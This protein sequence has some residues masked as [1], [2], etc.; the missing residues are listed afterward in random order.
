MALHLARVDV[1]STGSV[2]YEIRDDDGLLALGDSVEANHGGDAVVTATEL[3]D[4]EYRALEHLRRVD[5]ATYRLA[6]HQI[7]SRTTTW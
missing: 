1:L 5:G 4:E 7:S 2:Y 3:T 6:L